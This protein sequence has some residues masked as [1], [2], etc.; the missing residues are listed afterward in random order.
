MVRRKVSLEMIDEVA[1]YLAREKGLDALSL[2]SVARALGIKSPSLFN[3]VSGLGE[4]KQRIS[5]QALADLQQ[6]LQEGVHEKSGEAAVMALALAYRDWVTKNPGLYPAL[7]GV[8][9]S[10]NEELANLYYGIMKFMVSVFDVKDMG[11]EEQLHHGRALRALLHGWAELERSGS[12][13]LAQDIDWSY[14][15]AVADY[16]KGAFRGS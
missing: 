6:N 4:I 12:F 3:H 16:S 5:R 1:L 2:I 7:R 8:D 13:D 15:R 14:A 11:Q 9:P 10:S